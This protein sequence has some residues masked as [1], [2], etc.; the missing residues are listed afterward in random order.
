MGG[1]K[2]MVKV[3]GGKKTKDEADSGP[4]KEEKRWFSHFPKT[5]VIY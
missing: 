3:G 2:G 1:G 5:N 4:M